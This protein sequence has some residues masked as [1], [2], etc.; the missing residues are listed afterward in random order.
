MV[1]GLVKPIGDARNSGEEFVLVLSAVD[2][3]G[4]YGL[5]DKFSHYVERRYMHLSVPVGRVTI[6]ADV[7]AGLPGQC[8]AATNSGSSP[9]LSELFRA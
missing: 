4:A 3:D 7:C 8:F 9:L 5:I 6:S 2:L 1:D